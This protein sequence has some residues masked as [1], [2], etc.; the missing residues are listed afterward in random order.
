MTDREL[1]YFNYLSQPGPPYKIPFIKT[2]SDLSDVIPV[3]Y[4]TLIGED[5]IPDKETTWEELRDIGIKVDNKTKEKTIQIYQRALP[6]VKVGRLKGNM[7]YL[8]D[9]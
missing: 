5:K 4:T 7:E 1:I 3:N 9:C 2:V 6:I 8:E